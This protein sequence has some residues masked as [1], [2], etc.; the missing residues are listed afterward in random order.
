YVAPSG[1]HAASAGTYILYAAN[2]AAMAPGT[3]IGAATP[4][5]IGGGGIPG[6]PSPEEPLPGK[7]PKDKGK[8]KE[9]EAAKPPGTPARTLETKATNDAVALIRGLAE[10][11][12][13]NADWAEKAVREAATLNARQALES[14]V[15][16][17]IAADI[18]DLLRTLNGRKVTIG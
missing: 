10:L 1:A 5:Q 4:V 11:R 13:R 15:I 6:L 16:D 14:H 18:D 9:G 3:N 17:L 7:Q 12:G 2:I 8:C